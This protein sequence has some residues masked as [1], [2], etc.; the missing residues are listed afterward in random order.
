MIFCECERIEAG[1]EVTTGELTGSIVRLYR[2]KLVE[3]EL[4]DRGYGRTA[5]IQEVV[6]ECKALERRLKERVTHTNF[7]KHRP[8][9]VVKRDQKAWRLKAEKIAFG[10]RNLPAHLRHTAFVPSRFKA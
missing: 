6:L 1:C 5:E 4:A 9:G 8:V 10:R 7:D 2:T 3:R